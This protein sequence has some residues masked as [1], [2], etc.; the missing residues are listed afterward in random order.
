[1][2]KSGR[3][4]AAVLFL[5]CL[6]APQTLR[7][8]IRAECLSASSKILGHPV[9]YCVMLPPSYDTEKARRYPVLYLLHG[10]GDNEQM[11]IHSG[12]FN[13]VQ[14]LWERHQLGDF[15]I[16]TPDAGSSFYINSRDG[17]LRY[18]DFF[19]HEFLPQIEQRYRT[20]FGRASRG[21]AGISMG[22]YGA[23][24]LGFRH[25]ELFASVGAHSAALLE[26]LPTVT[27]SD[28]RQTAR[29]RILGDV[30]GSPL[31]PVFWKQNDPLAL[32]RTANLSALKIY[33]DCGS[34][35]DFGFE[36]GAAALDKVLSS[37]RVPHEFH[38]YPG[39]HN[40]VYVAEHLPALLQFHFRSFESASRH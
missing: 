12:G 27:I 24:H 31:D 15:L 36:D 26:K 32:A 25:P 10:L 20:R 16:V 13:L 4:A 3:V 5:S 14:D 35:D 19:L 28:S 33:I 18:E 6:A 8:S 1:M 30:F 34:E 22:G 39:G 21:I 38:L 40:W 37:R 29:S 7:A 9:A 23:L 11:L 17:R 2:N